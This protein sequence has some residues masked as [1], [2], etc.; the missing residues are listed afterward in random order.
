M[1]CVMKK[2]PTP[3]PF[4]QIIELNKST[5]RF[6]GVTWF[7]WESQNKWDYTYILISPSKTWCNTKLFSSRDF[8]Y[9]P[10]YMEIEESLLENK[11]IKEHGHP[12]TGAGHMY[13]IS[14]KDEK[15]FAEFIITNRYN[16]HIFSECDDHGLYNGGIVIFP[17]TPSYD[18]VE[19]QNKAV[20]ASYIRSHSA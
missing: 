5:Y 18:S 15:L 1:V 13:G 6:T 20:L 7:Y 3:W 8:D 14:W 11:S 9:L 16:E 17:Q 19:K 4:G 12:L 10:Y 2:I